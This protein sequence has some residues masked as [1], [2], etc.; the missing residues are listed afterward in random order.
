MGGTA[1][2]LSLIINKA[3][4]ALTCGSKR[5]A[6]SEED[7]GRWSAAQMTA[8]PDTSRR[9]G[10]QAGEG[11]GYAGRPPRTCCPG[12]AANGGCAGISST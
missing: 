5:R 2:L 8:K 1:P 6:N 12:D 9:V 7:T 3:S 10:R 4:V 11:E